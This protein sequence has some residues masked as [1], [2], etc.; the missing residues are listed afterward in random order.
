MNDDFV[1]GLVV[2]AGCVAAAFIDMAAQDFELTLFNMQRDLVSRLPDFG[3]ELTAVI[4]A[5]FV[6][7]VRGRRD[8][9]QKQGERK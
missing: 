1:A 6:D 4:A 5:S 2:G 3:D 8:E 7:A 9:L